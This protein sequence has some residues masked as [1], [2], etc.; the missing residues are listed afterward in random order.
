MRIM[1][2]AFAAAMLPG[3]AF[4]GDTLISPMV[5]GLDVCPAAINKGITSTY[6][7]AAYCQS[8]KETSADLIEK[9]L[10]EFGPKESADG[11]FQIGYTLSV[12]LL[13]YVDV[14]PDGSFSIDKEK[15]RYRLQLLKDTDRQAVVYIFSNHFSVSENAR[16]ED[17]IAKADSASLMQLSDGKV[18]IDGYFSSKTYP[19]AINA[20]G[21]LID[22]VRKVALHEV[23]TQICE[24]DNSDKNKIRA[25]TVLGEVHYTFPDFF[26]GMGYK[27]KMQITDY[28]PE[29]VKRF[30][31]YL[32]AKYK[33]IE[34]LNSKLGSEF[35]SFDDINPPSKDIN[36]DHLN[37]FFEHMDYAS[38]GKLAIYGWAAGTDGKP[39]KIKIFVDGNDAGYAETGLNRMDVY[40]AIPSLGTSAVGYRYYLD[41]RKMSHGIHTVDV[42]H[43]DAGKLTMLKHL[44]VPVMD[45]QQTAPRSVGRTVTFP[46]EQKMR[47]W[48]D[49]PE[50]MKA[51]YYNPLSEEF[52]D[53]RKTAV[54]S[55]ISEY[56]D[57]VSSSCIG[58]KKTFSHQI[59]PIFNADWNQEKIAAS[60]SL[61]NN[62]HYNIGM[63]TYGAAFY[64]DYTFQ[65]IKKLGITRYGI[66]EAHP[67]VGNE[68]IIRDALER[69]HS[70][71]AVFISPYYVDI[72]PLNF[73]VDK[74]HAKFEIK[75][76]N[77]QYHSDAYFNA[78]RDV[79]TRN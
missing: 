13:S 28:S 8:L 70:S 2:F 36:I 41:F 72:K 24:M 71:G 53:F 52:Y 26:N 11:K 69:H 7:A 46:P 30:R 25:V 54:A 14:K 19:W 74:D 3:T 73:G 16:T 76:S 75:E 15:I 61:K 18:P 79:M 39:A 5:G 48:N 62:S 35:K 57:I 44:D 42:V 77:K 65:W 34:V 43:D 63:N 55:E 78:I 45:R 20:E 50:S 29:S 10:S 58:K 9:K 22:R 59:A 64:G 23:L 68:D 47:F 66:P 27:G 1:P 60:D 56:A 40:Q 33:T 21:S 31:E 37:N 49:Y 51:V 17:A 38:S 12:P 6:D 4:A 67:M 32:S